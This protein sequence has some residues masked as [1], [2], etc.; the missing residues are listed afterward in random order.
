[1]QRFRRLSADLDDD[2]LFFYAQYILE[3]SLLEASF[4]QFKPSYLA[5]A[6]IILSCKQLKKTDCWTSEMKELTGYSSSDLSEVV[7]EV[8]LFCHEINPKFISILKYKF[9]KAEYK[10]VSNYEFKFWVRTSK[11]VVSS[12]CWYIDKTRIHKNDK[13][14]IIIL[15]YYLHKPQY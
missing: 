12:V 3:I 8:R 9:S 7:K 13:A 1:M 6:A 10:K 14:D 15:I 5:A 4:L 11:G 2:E